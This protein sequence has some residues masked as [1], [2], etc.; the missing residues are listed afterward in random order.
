MTKDEIFTKV[1]AIICEELGVKEAQ[2]T[3]EANLVDDL[4]ADS[5][6]SVEIIV[7]LEDE[8]GLSVSD[9]AAQNIKT[10]GDIVNVIAENVK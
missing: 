1:Q 7:K 2:V 5:L 3:M 9:E 4:Q 10:V 8:F 6:D